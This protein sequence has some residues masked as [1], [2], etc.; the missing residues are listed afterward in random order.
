MLR[1]QPSRIQITQHDIDVMDDLRVQRIMDNPDLAI[2][3]PAF[4]RKQAQ[5]KLAQLSAQPP[6]TVHSDILQQDQ[7]HSTM[8]DVFTDT[9][10]RDAE[11]RENEAEQGGRGARYLLNQFQQARRQDIQ[12]RIGL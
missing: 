8:E 7:L 10:V 4:L 5:A 3:A 11:I 12:S 6:D 9:T 2:K 1:I